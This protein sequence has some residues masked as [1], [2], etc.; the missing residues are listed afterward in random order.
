MELTYP[1]KKT[2]LASHTTLDI[3]WASAPHKENVEP[4]LAPARCVSIDGCQAK[5][6][7]SRVKII[8]WPEARTFGTKKSRKVKRTFISTKPACLGS[9]YKCCKVYH[10]CASNFIYPTTKKGCLH[11]LSETPKMVGSW[12]LSL[13]LDDKFTWVP[14]C[15]NGWWCS[16][17]AWVMFDNDESQKR[18]QTKMLIKNTFPRSWLGWRSNIEPD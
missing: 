4:N 3:R 18:Q 14:D 6:H 16:Y 11:D 5:M 13:I 9:R 1:P 10:T 12:L 15:W 8:E 2:T 7:N 17:L